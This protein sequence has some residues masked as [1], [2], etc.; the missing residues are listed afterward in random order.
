MRKTRRSSTMKTP[1]PPT[2]K[3]QRLEWQREMRSSPGCKLRFK[4]EKPHGLSEKESKKFS[5]NM[6]SLWPLSFLPLVSL[7][8]LL[9]VQLPMP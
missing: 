6:V 4:K 9:L 7:S 1:H 3:L 8:D 5:K 2:E